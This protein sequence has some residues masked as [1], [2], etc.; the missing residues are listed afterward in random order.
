M[1]LDD[2]ALQGKCDFWWDMRRQQE[3]QGAGG[4]SRVESRVHSAIAASALITVVT[5]AAAGLAALTAAH[6]RNLRK[7]FRYDAVDN[8]ALALPPNHTT[9]LKWQQELE[10]EQDEEEAGVGYT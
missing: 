8:D 3:L 5:I 7:F 2:V 9:P 10:K 1:Q 4:G 6:V